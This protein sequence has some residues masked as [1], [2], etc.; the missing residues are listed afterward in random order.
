MQKKSKERE[1]KKKKNGVW[2]NLRR[3]K[4]GSVTKQP[5]RPM[6]GIKFALAGA[7]LG[8]ALRCPAGAGERH[9]GSSYWKEGP[10][11]PPPPPPLRCFRRDRGGAKE[12]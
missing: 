7:D 4:I 5:S 12:G 9:S 1:V 3:G 2:R 10:L 6:R 8:P 11:D